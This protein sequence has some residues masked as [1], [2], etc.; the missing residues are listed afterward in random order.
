M[1]IVKA[2]VMGGSYANTHIKLPYSLQ[3]LGIDIIICF[4][5]R[6]GH[7]R[8]QVG[9]S[10]SIV[11]AKDNFNVI[12]LFLGFIFPVGR[13]MFPDGAGQYIKKLSQ[14]ISINGAYIA[15]YFLEVG[16]LLLPGGYLVIS[17]LPVQWPKQDKEWSDLQPERTR[18]CNGI[19]IIINPSLMFLDETTS[20]LDS[21]TAL[22][23]V[24]MLH[25]IAATDKS[26]VTTIHHPSSRIFHKFDKLILLGRRSLLC[27]GKASEAMDYFQFIG[28]TP[29]SAMN[30]TKFLLY[31]ANGNIND[32]SVPSEL[33][34]KMQVGNA[35]GET[36]NGKPSIA[37]VQEYLV[38]AYETR[39][40]EIEKKIF[41]PLFG[42][43]DTLIEVL[44]FFLVSNS[45]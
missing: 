21:T 8:V 44:G 30:R 10:N 43:G 20:G 9:S 29:L 28:C 17:G 26:V 11:S 12:I 27:F 7:K 14:Y 18:V 39:V 33:K 1:A 32:A 45:I 41:E 15:T 22:R 42:L 19:E 38:E 5:I 6:L 34:V 25:D 40:A 3:A 23:K 13:I 24:Q 4:G 2:G 37:I 35:E 31:L 16:R 36:R